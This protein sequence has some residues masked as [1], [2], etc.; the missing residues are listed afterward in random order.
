LKNEV[1][2]GIMDAASRNAEQVHRIITIKTPQ[3]GCGIR[4]NGKENS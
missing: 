3:E 4:E 2:W 1:F